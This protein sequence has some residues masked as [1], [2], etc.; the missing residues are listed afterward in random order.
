MWTPDYDPY[1]DEED[2]KSEKEKTHTLVNYYINELKFRYV[3]KYKLLKSH[4]ERH[5]YTLIQEVDS[6]QNNRELIWQSHI[7]DDENNI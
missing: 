3:S 6:L 1:D 5:C 4:Y 2:D 7:T